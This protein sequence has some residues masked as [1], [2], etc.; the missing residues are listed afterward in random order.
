M[1]PSKSMNNSPREC[2]STLSILIVMFGRLLAVRACSVACF[3][4]SSNWLKVT[5]FRK[6]RLLSAFFGS[7]IFS[8]GP[9]FS[10]S[11]KI[12]SLSLGPSL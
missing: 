5:F 10:T 4:V 3:S 9:V 2:S 11:I 6:L 12:M 7:G 8:L 1:E